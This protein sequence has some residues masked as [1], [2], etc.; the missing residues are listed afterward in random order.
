VLYSPINQVTVAQAVVGVLQLGCAV[1]GSFPGPVA[2]LFLVG[3]FGTAN[4]AFELMRPFGGALL[5]GVALASVSLAAVPFVTCS[6]AKFSAVFSCTGDD[7]EYHLAGS[8]ASAALCGAALVLARTAAQ[9]AIEDR[10][11]LISDQLDDLLAGDH[12][13]IE[14]DLNR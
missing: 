8:V 4:A 6:S 2:M 14:D 13:D 12:A 11:A 10:L 5:G 9:S 1:F 3:A 7:P